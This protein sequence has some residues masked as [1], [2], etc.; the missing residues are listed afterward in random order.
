MTPI[1]T[2]NR[3]PNGAVF[4]AYN[5]NDNSKTNGIKLQS[6]SI[7][8]MQWVSKNDIVRISGHTNLFFN[9][10]KIMI[11]ELDSGSIFSSCSM[12]SAG[13]KKH[14]FFKLTDKEVM[15]HVILEMI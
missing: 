1:K 8:F 15:E 12:K 9:D 2:L 13:W 3:P 11:L 4:L 14:I 6:K 10:G 5:Y 7:H